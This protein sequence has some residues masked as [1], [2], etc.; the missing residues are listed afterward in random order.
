MK[1]RFVLLFLSF[2]ITCV[3]VV[4]RQET[5]KPKVVSISPNL[6]NT[7]TEAQK[8]T[9]TARQLMGEHAAVE[10]F[11]YSP[12]SRTDCFVRHHGAN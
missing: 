7:Y 2:A 8:R 5:V 6:I 3:I 4:A 9:E 10:R 1:S 12:E 11:H